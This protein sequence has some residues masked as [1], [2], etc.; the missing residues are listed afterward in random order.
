MLGSVRARLI[1]SFSLV[2]GL[3][4]FLAGVGA[5]FLLRDQQQATARERYGH[6][7]EPISV[8]VSALQ[9]AGVSLAD[10]TPYLDQAAQQRGVRVLLLDSD[11]S[12]V[13][14]SARTL[15]GK[16]ILSFSTFNVRTYD[17]QGTNFTWVD[18]DSNG[19]HLTLFA[20]PPPPPTG[21]FTVPAYETIVAIP[22]SKLSAAWH[23]LVP[24]LALAG[25][26]S[27]T[28]SFIVSFFISRSI[29]GPLA[30]ITQASRQM[31]KGDYDVHIP[32]RGEDEVGR[33]SEAFNAMAKQVSTSQRMMKDLLANVSH[34][35]KTPLTS[36][37]GYSQAMV[38]G[39]V[40]EQEG[41][42]ESSR[43]I[44]EEANR[45]R[46][47]VDDLLLLSQI[48]SGQTTMQHTH[49]DLTAL[50]QRMLERFQWAC[51][52]A[53][54]TTRL[55]IGR[56][57]DVHGDER[58][59]E[60]VFSNLIENAVR[61][62]PRDGI[63]TISESMQADGSMRVGVHNTGSVIPPEDLPRVFERFFQV[64]RARA[65]KGGS[66][67]LGLS[68]VSEIVEAHGGTVRAESDL[69]TGTEFIVTLP[70]APAH[71]SRNGRGAPDSAKRAPRRRRDRSERIA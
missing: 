59:L 20:A 7:A 6:L 49:V 67:G 29:S 69:G 26:I 51:R 27:L 70:P 13:Y 16:Y 11:L 2:V 62:T 3:A 25:A 38:D 56:V 31:A 1:V 63:V 41:Y 17:S 48:E 28:V 30:R 68:I 24:S 4:V 9:Q 64:D 61:H 12:V 44:H 42:R 66:S 57:G 5:L 19:T 43:I 39:A 18:Y 53:G 46:A 55:R 8:Q 32:I 35:L 10:M 50:L 45:M 36:I 47:L 71:D 33:L 15:E 34:E 40:R 54:I 52:E 21:T 60:Q 37:Q 22:Q 23:D 14:D 65:R 58:R